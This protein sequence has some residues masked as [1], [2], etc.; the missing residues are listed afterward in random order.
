VSELRITIWCHNS[1]SYFNEWIKVI[2]LFEFLI[3]SFTQLCSANSEISS[4]KLWIYRI[5]HSTAKM[6]RSHLFFL[7]VVISIH[8]QSYGHSIQRTFAL[9][10]LLVLTCRPISAMNAE[11]CNAYFLVLFSSYLVTTF[12][13]LLELFIAYKEVEIPFWQKK[14]LWGVWRSAEVMNTG[15][16]KVGCSAVS[17]KAFAIEHPNLQY[18]YAQA[19]I[20]YSS[21]THYKVR[22]LESREQERAPLFKETHPSLASATSLHWSLLSRPGFSLNIIDSYPSC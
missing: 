4:G 7:T 15:N 10:P 1:L 13:V 20:K 21:L 2:N 18:W 22:G 16:R 9:C 12:C 3:I 14:K 19:F 5:F 17:H 11:L 6:W 8:L